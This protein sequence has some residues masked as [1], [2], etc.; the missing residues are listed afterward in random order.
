VAEGVLEVEAP[1]E[2]EV[3]AHPAE[4]LPIQENPLVNTNVEDPADPHPLETDTAVTKNTTEVQTD[5]LTT[6]ELVV[7]SSP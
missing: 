1:M 3:A 7:H 5:T 4:A 2:V 6:T